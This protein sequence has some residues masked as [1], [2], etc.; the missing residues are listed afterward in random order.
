MDR[1]LEMQAFAAVV[2]AGSFVRAADALG[3]SKPALSRYVADL[4][5]RL[6][7]RLLHRTTRKLSLTD[8]GR[9]F[10]ARCKSVLTEVD[11]AEA[12]ATAR[13]VQA[14]GLLKISVPVTFGLLHLAPL[15]SDFMATHP[16]V[17]MDVTLSDRVVDLVE[18]GFDLAVRIGYLTDSALVSRQL[19]S[20][21]MVL[22]A[23]PGYLAQHGHPATLQALAEHTVIAYSLLSTGDQWTLNGPHGPETVL[24]HPVLRT[25]S[26]DTCRAAAL[27][28]QG[29][30][31]QPSFL[32]ADD[33]RNGTLVELLPLYQCAEF[34]IHAV[35]PS[36][37]FV[38][39][40][41]R[42]LIAFLVEAFSGAQWRST[43]A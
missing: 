20:T 15:W 33:L 26:G 37:K 34:G 43:A 9:A 40:K 24:V 16:Q 41:V 2:D 13:A 10:Y 36:R 19:A 23:S 3:A 14:S 4:E 39:A 12:E 35:Y 42:L 1:F 8:E 21:R 31:L 38:P 29:I 22:C 11:D 5:T 17:R 28:H 27:Q 30:I 25:N 32:V 7:V 6:G 18:E